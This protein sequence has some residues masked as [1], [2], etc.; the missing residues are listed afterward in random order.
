M[1]IR[2]SV[3]TTIYADDVAERNLTRNEADRQRVLEISTQELDRKL[4]ELKMA[5]NQGKAEHL[6]MYLGEGS[7]TETRQALAKQWVEGQG[8]IASNA[9]YLGNIEEVEGKGRLNV[10]KRIRAME[11]GWYGKTGFWRRKDISYKKKR[12]LFLNAVFNTGLSGMEP[13]L[14]TWR[15]LKAIDLVVVKYLRQLLGEDSAWCISN[16]QEGGEVQNVYHQKSNKEV[17]TMMRVANVDSELR[18]RRL[19]WLQDII[20]HPDDN[21]QLRAAVFGELGDD[22]EPEELNPWADRWIQDLKLLLSHWEGGMNVVD[23]VRMYGPQILA[24]PTYMEWLLKVDVS[25]VR[26]FEDIESPTGAE[27]AMVDVAGDGFPCGFLLHTGEACPRVFDKKQALWMHQRSSHLV[28]NSYTRCVLTNE[29]PMCRA[30]CKTV[31]SAQ[32]HVSRTIKY[33]RCADPVKRLKCARFMG[34]NVLE[35]LTSVECKVC[36]ET[37]TGHDTIPVSYTH[38]TL[39]TKR[40]V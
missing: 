9:K 25:I 5:Q 15:D 30:L 8:R 29:C 12:G 28:R 7:I 34:E 18:Y 26:S 13:E 27:E 36:K 23:C 20:A 14:S 32:G 11:E 31:E 10:R 19:K 39:P 3:S 16:P 24:D 1:C 37:V 17:R 21:V 33:R 40:I 2:D 38:L 4:T 22:L 6:P 35:E